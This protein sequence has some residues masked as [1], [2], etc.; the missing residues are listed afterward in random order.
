VKEVGCILD[1]VIENLK[2]KKDLFT[3]IRRGQLLSYE[4]TDETLGQVSEQV[5]QDITRFGSVKT[6][7]EARRE[8]EAICFE[9]VL[10]VLEQITEERCLVVTE[11]N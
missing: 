1:D 9:D 3:M 5:I 2:R 11:Y 6:I 4:M 8:T 7:A 10:A